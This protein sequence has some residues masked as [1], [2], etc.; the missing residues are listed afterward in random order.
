MLTLQRILF[1]FAAEVLKQKPK[2][3]VAKTGE[4]LIITKVLNVSG[5]EGD[6]V[7]ASLNQSTRR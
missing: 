3:A 2:A 6:P 5:Q 7:P 1:V 4:F